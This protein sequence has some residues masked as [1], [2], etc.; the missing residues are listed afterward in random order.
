[1]AKKELN[2]ALLP[3]APVLLAMTDDKA[4]SPGAMVIPE[5]KL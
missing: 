4:R 1:M 3:L 5:V 2:C